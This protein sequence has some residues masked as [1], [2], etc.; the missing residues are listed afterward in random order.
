MRTGFH[1]DR[2]ILII[3]HPESPTF[4]II[5]IFAASTADAA[6]HDAADPSVRRSIKSGKRLRTAEEKND[7][8]REK[9]EQRD[10]L[11]YIP[12]LTPTFPLLLLIS[13]N[14]NAAQ[15]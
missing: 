3:D 10:G 1:C 7:N 8:E 9:R 6:C 15:G 11:G 4:T 13:H 12:V 14:H 5:R 2:A